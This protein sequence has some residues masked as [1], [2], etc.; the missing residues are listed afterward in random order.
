VQVSLGPLPP[1]LREVLG[2]WIE[3]GRRADPPA[4][5]ERFNGLFIYGG[6]IFCCYLDAAGELFCWGAWDDTVERLEDGPQKVG[7]IAIAAEYKPELAE[8]LPDR[9]PD[10]VTCGQ[11]GGSGR[12]NPPGPWIQCP[13]CAGLGWVVPV[14]R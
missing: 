11:C 5:D 4:V 13:E 8:W 2:Q 9:P 10:A 6:P 3:A 1:Q 7:I 14:V 12:L